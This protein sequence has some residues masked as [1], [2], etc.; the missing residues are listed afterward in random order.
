M[1][2]CFI[3]PDKTYSAF[4]IF[5]ISIDRYIL[6]IPDRNTEAGTGYNILGVFCNKRRRV[7]TRAI[8]NF[9]NLSSTESFQIN[10]GN[11]GSVIGI[12]KYPTS[13]MY[14]ICNRECYMM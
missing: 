1:T 4:K 6:F 11:P 7:V 8:G 3:N 10:P 5:L 13:V 14:A 9:N 2:R 12:C